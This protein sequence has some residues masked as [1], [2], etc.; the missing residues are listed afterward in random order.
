MMMISGASPTRDPRRM[1]R[2]ALGWVALY[3]VLRIYWSLGNQPEDLGPVQ[4]DLV[5]FTGWG[6]VAL[7]AAAMVFLTVLLTTRAT[8]AA[9]RG[10]LLGAWTVCAALAA[11][12][13]LLLLDVIGGILPGLGLEFSGMGAMSRAGCAGASALVG[14]TTLAYQRGTRAGCAECG[15]RERL[16]SVPAW[17][18][19]AAYLSMAGCLARLG[20]QLSVGMDNMPYEYN[21]SM[22]VFDVGFVLAGT[23]LPLALV[24]SY[25]RVWP[26]WVPRLAG[27][28]VPRRLV[29]WPAAA[30]S[31]GLV[32]YFGLMLVQMVY[33]RLNGRNPFPPE[34]GLD[35]PELFFWVAVPAYLLWGA[36]MAAAALAYARRTRSECGACGR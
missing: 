4:D 34:P 22:V 8:G 1:A 26:R 3:S 36:G 9:R 20:A 23:V 6:S 27:R 25:G 13:A 5:I 18:F 21:A 2:L 31:S 29:L 15:G 24:H 11:A 12:A 32:V 33:E 28:A 10:L 14:L 30:I 7:C 17:A 19:W 16:G 35:L